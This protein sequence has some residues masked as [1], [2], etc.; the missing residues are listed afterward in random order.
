MRDN[1]LG[2]KL[3]GIEQTRDIWFQELKRNLL[4]TI[5]R[6][7]SFHLYDFK[8]TVKL[9]KNAE[10]TIIIKLLPPKLFFVI[11]TKNWLKNI[12]LEP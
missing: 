10:L 9:L 8:I 6:S 1:F 7:E 5:I 4:G 12:S 11:I 2:E 3:R